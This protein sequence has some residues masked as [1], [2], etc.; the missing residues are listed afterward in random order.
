MIPKFVI[1]GVEHSGTTLL[2]D[3]FRQV[4]GLDSGFEVGVLLCDSP[5]EFRHFEPFIT[6]MKSGWGITDE[7]LDYI[8]DVETFVEFYVRLKEAS[9]IIDKN[10]EIFDK[11]PRYFHSLSKCIQK[12]ECNFI[13][14]YKDPRSIVYSDFK[15][16]KVKNFYKWY[17][18]YK[19]AK[20]RYL[21]RIYEE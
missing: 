3:L 5:K 6:N 17:E 19:L 1:C 13:A 12:V 7:Q 21:S 2:S 14:T 8:C 11:T 4:H 15:R 18:Q 9:S 20:L 10:S 16:V